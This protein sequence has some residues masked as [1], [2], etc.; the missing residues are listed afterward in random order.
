MYRQEHRQFEE[1]LT[2]F[3][4]YLEDKANVSERNRLIGYLLLYIGVRV[5]E[6][7]SVRLEDISLMPS[8]LTVKG[9]GG[10][11]REISL[12]Q[13]VLAYMKDY[14]QGEREESPFHSSSYLLVSQRVEKLH[15]DAVRN[16]LSHASKELQIHLHPHLFRHTF[17]TRLLR[18]VGWIKENNCTHV[19]L[20]I[21]SVYRKHIVNLL[22]A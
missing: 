3:L 15:R 22:E 5:S 18:M 20:E 11:I 17:A 13:D 9:K 14:M 2:Q 10:K 12:R 4:F 1:F 6:L 21:T 16:W 7:V 8:A 19:A